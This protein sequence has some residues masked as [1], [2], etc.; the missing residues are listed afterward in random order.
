MFSVAKCMSRLRN[1]KESS[2]G[3]KDTPN[4][5][6]SRGAALSS[7]SKSKKMMMMFTR[8]KF[9]IINVVSLSQVLLS[10]YLM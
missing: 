6:S 1:A 9:L 2:F 8:N 4:V 3:L 10:V 5:S 7:S